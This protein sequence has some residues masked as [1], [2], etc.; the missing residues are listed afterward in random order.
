[1]LSPFLIIP[2]TSPICPPESRFLLGKNGNSSK[3]SSKFSSSYIWFEATKIISGLRSNDGTIEGL[4][5]VIINDYE[6][7]DKTHFQ[8]SIVDSVLDIGYPNVVFIAFPSDMLAN[9]AFTNNYLKIKKHP[10]LTIN[11]ILENETEVSLNLS[12]NQYIA[13]KKEIK[14]MVK[15]TKKCNKFINC[16]ISK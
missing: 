2:Q 6:K 4:N 16:I 12:Y 1:M 13:I 8:V 10:K 7:G 14:L 9:Q 11:S 3:D 15:A 5:I